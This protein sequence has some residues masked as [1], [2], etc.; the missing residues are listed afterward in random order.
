[1]TAIAG[2]LP[3][4][5]SI[6]VTAPM[7]AIAGKLPHDLSSNNSNNVFTLFLMKHTTYT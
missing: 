4:E 3:V 6:L 2:K 1:L 7:T 5:K